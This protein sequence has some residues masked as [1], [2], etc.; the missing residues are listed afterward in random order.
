VTRNTETRNGLVADGLSLGA[1]ES[2]DSDR[3]ASAGLPVTDSELPA[4]VAD[5]ARDSERPDRLRVETAWLAEH[6]SSEMA[7]RSWA[8]ACGPLAVTYRRSG[9][10]SRRVLRDSWGLALIGDPPRPAQSDS[11]DPPVTVRDS[12][13]DHDY[14]ER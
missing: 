3:P 2:T 12:G 13:G 4:A 1:A 8:I 11:D 7:S 5:A 14:V 9:R 10:S 6:D